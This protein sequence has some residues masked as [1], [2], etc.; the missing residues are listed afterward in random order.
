MS[1]TAVDYMVPKIRA[2]WRDSITDVYPENTLYG[3]VP[4]AAAAAVV[5]TSVPIYWLIHRVKCQY[6]LVS[7]V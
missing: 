3:T 6:S 4:A 7:S 2:L 1:P 5:G